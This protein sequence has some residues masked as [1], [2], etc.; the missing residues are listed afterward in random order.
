MQIVG[1]IACNRG[2]LAPLVYHKALSLIPESDREARGEIWT[3]IREALLKT[4]I[5]V[6]QAKVW[7]AE[8]ALIP[9]VKIEDLPASRGV[10]EWGPDDVL[11]QKGVDYIVSGLGPHGRA[12]I[13]IAEK[14]FPEISMAHNC[15]LKPSSLS[16]QLRKTMPGLFPLTD[17]L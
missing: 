15:P 2:E 10:R 4:M 16:G 5:I 17:C 8:K 12:V 13:P 1:L 14:L 6:G 3:R 7:A 11:R 9:A